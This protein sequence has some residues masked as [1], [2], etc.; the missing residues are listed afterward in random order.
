MGEDQGIRIINCGLLYGLFFGTTTGIDI[1][2]LESQT[3][4][5]VN[6]TFFAG[7]LG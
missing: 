2:F 4:I 3:K 5:I 7:F 6:D 1:E